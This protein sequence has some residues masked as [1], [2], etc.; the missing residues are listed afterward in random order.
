MNDNEFT[1]PVGK[2]VIL[3]DGV[4]NLC[5]DS[6]IKVIKN[7]RKNVFVFSPLQSEIGQKITHQLSI[8]SAKVDSII[9]YEPNG[10]YYIKSAAALRVMKEFSGFWK[11]SQIFRILPAA[12]SDLFYDY[13]AK[14]RYKWF[15]KKDYCMIPTP[16]LEEKFL[17]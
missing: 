1:I 13:I 10:T 5:N 16:E 4:C 17:A 11:I 14:N 7:D 8:N 15:G 12:F 2:K 6:V 9:L 3:F